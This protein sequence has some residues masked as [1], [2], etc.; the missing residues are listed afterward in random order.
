MKKQNRVL[1]TILNW[2]LGHASRC[3]PIIKKL[4]EYSFEII[5]AS[6]GRSA[7]LLKKE[8]PELKLIELPAY[9]IR[10]S[11][12]NMIFNIAYQ[13]PKILMAI[14][15]ENR[16]VKK[17]V[18]KEQIDIIISDHRYGCKSKST[19]NIFITHQINIII[20]IK[21]LE[22]LVNKINH[23][24]INRFNE[25]WVPDF[26]GEKGLAGRLS[27]SGK[28]KNLKYLG[29]LSRL[30][31][32]K[33]PKEY[34]VIA[35]ISGPEPQRTKFENKIVQELKS[36]KYK[37]LIVQGKANEKNQFQLNKNIEVISFLDSKQL[38]I[39]IQSSEVV[40]CR[41][42]YSSIMDLIKI[43]K[44]AILVPT[45]GQTEQE[46]LALKLQE[47]RQFCVQQQATFSLKKGLKEIENYSANLK[48][49][50]SFNPIDDVINT[51]RNQKLKKHLA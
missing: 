41:S 43:G 6:D 24:L 42:G 12:N 18:E 27:K 38:N 39:A 10:Y 14:W 8:F 4:Q 11:T 21:P 17:L 7:Q 33:V 37:S 13:F 30:E 31:V 2:G 5:L 22:W 16:F 25:C 1:V 45:P 35:V 48:L 49:A 15:K 36:T 51:L 44:K 28:L 3:I 23:F 32:I 20:P 19:K 26:E 50:D 29:P 9:N 34:D 40:I 46:Y 47:K